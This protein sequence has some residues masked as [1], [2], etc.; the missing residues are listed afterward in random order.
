MGSLDTTN[1]RWN[2]LEKTLTSATASQIV[3]R[4]SYQAD[5][6][7]SATPTLHNGALYFPTWKGSVVC[8]D[9]TTGALRWRVNIVDVLK[10]LGVAVAAGDENYIVSRASPAFDLTTNAKSERFVLGTMMRNVGG[11]PY[12]VSIDAKTGKGLWATKLDDNPA[13]LV[14]MSATIHNRHAFVGTSSLEEARAGAMEY[15]CCSF[16]GSLSRVEL[17]TGRVIWKTYT[18]PVGWSGAAAWGSMPS[19]DASRGLVLFAT[20]DNYDYPADVEDCLKALEPLTNANAPQQAACEK[21]SGGEQNYRNAMVALDLESGR[22]RWASKLGGPDAWNAACFI[23]G[24]P[25]CP[26]AAGPG[27]LFVSFGEKGERVAAPCRTASP[28]FSLEPPQPPPPHSYT[29][30]TTTPQPPS[31]THTHT[32]QTT[33]TQ[34]GTLAK[35]P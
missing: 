16:R 8:L 15:K 34:T 13:A 5:G 2:G 35:R 33:K 18:T 6:D 26:A 4:W 31:N 11:Y 27:E 29:H 3:E 32:P 19:I 21:L 25:N 14:T 9:A 20:G 30:T 7:V 12:L 10:S 1:R 17:A 28:P 24:H 22:V 23:E